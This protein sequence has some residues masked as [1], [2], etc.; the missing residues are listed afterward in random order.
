MLSKDSIINLIHIFVFFP[1]LAYVYYLGINKKLTS[2]ICRSMIMVGI[3][4]ILYHAYLLK[5]SKQYRMWVYL[6][7]ILIV[8]PLLIIIGYN[9]EDTMRMFFEML[10][11]ASF[12]ALG[13]H[14]FL[15]VKY[16]L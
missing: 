12:A 11:L 9:C 10:L 13:Y 5:D 4:G 16:S 8:F 3:I 6:T 7:H 15:F 14:S 2:G 1:A